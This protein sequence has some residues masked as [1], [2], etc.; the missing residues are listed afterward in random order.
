MIVKR[1]KPLTPAPASTHR[2]MANMTL[3]TGQHANARLSMDQARAIR[4]AHESKLAS[5]AQLAARYR[6]S[7]ACVSAI[8]HGKS[9]KD[10]GR[11]SQTRAC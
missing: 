7:K 8:I 11:V 9:Y 4:A 3:P 10:T 5:M 6:I 2:P 1:D